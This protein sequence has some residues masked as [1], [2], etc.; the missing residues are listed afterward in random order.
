MWPLGQIRCIIPALK[1]GHKCLAGTQPGNTV[2]CAVLNIFL[3]EHCTM[4]TYLVK[5][6]NWVTVPLYVSKIN[7]LMLKVA[8]PSKEISIKREE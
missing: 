5:P 7:N 4:V 6:W 3:E 2:F 8:F 1:T